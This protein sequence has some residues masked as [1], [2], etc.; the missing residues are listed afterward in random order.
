MR[1]NILISAYYC[2]P[3]RG[4]ESAVGWRIATKLAENHDVTVICGD[5]AANGLTGADMTRFLKEDSLPPGLKIHHIQ[6]EG[7][8][9]RIHDLHA[10]PGLWFLFYVAYRRWQLQ[11][12]QVAKELHDDTPFDMI[13]HV[14]VIGFREPGYLWQMGVPFLWGP[15]S[16]APMVPISFLKDFSPK[17]KFRWGSRNIL[18]L[19]QIHLAGRAAE[20][21]RTAIKVWVVSNEDQQVFKGWGVKVERM[22]ETGCTVAE[23]I[24]PRT[25]EDNEPLRLCWSG[26]FQGIK[27]L[28]ILLK[29]MASSTRKDI[30]LDVLGDGVEA[31]SWKNLAAAMGLDKRVKWHGMLARE[32][33]LKT[34]HNAHVLIHTS[35]KEGTP[36]VVLEAMAMG[37]PVICHDACGMGTAVTPNC[38]IKIPMVDPQSSIAGFRDAILRLATEPKLL[39]SLSA[40]A[41]A[42][43]GELSWDAKIETFIDTYRQIIANTSGGVSES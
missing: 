14:N 31:G 33:A 41:L 23:G 18:N 39:E 13:H 5:L 34:M 27:A 32:D 30:T 21:A 12:L 19:L 29:A 26:L 40:G 9:R 16:G 3:Y 1:L 42:R 4:G 43:A 10:L 2:S 7:W 15:A 6:A 8:T 24:R 37:M 17:E 35:V 36:H 25:K 20:A 22:L 28:P 11:I 38:G